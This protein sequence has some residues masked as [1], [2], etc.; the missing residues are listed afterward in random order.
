MVS[1][2]DIQNAIL[3]AYGYM[4]QLTDELATEQGNGCIDCYDASKIECLLWLS[5]DLQDRVDRNVSGKETDALYEQLL[6]ALSGYNY[7]SVVDP[8]ASIPYT[9]I[10]VGGEGGGAGVWGMIIGNI[11]DQEDLMALLATKADIGDGLITPVNVY[12]V[13][14]DA[15]IEAQSGSQITWKIGTTIVS[16]PS[17]QTLP[18]ADATDNY[19]RKD[20]IAMT[21]SGLIVVQGVESQNAATPPNLTSGQ[22]GLTIVDVYGDIINSEP[23]QPPVDISAPAWTVYGNVPFGKY[24]NL[25]TVPAAASA[26]EQYKEAWT[27]IA[28]PNYV[29][30]TASLSSTP[31]TSGL[32]IGQSVNVNLSLAFNQ[33]NA[34]AET[35]RLITK[36][37]S[38][39]G[40]TTDT[41]T[42]AS[43]PVV[44]QGNVDYGQG[45]VLN[46]A[47]GIPDPVGR[48]AAGNVNSNSISYS[49]IYPWFWLKSN[50]PISAADMQA[51]IA[52]GTA[53]KVIGSSTGTINVP[54]APNGEYM[55]VAYPAANTTKTK[56]FVTLLS[57]GNVPGGVFSGQTTL[58]V[59]SPEGRWTGINYKIHT[60]P[61]L[62]NPSAP[63]IE[64]RNS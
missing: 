24:G 37:G 15:V 51:A 10:N 53:T 4:V 57:N 62:T 48:I 28:H 16:H 11:Q 64:L 23:P 13:G 17:P 41:I 2:L 19:F 26:F 61:L 25:Q 38:P 8:N 20:W 55:A 12:I 29:A 6:E 56:W 42:I 18:I 36:N 35:S 44:Y 49:G 32:E 33:N 39:L 45:A 14:S 60:T 43:T 22:I 40:G 5:E 59:N 9:I 52:A 31:S 54:Y 30:P 58:A 50:S 3:R 34:G 47:A 46:N 1:K 27:N 21:T 7:E 63:I